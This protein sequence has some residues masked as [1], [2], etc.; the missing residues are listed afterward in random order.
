[1][2]GVGGTPRD[3]SD[4]PVGWDTRHGGESKRELGDEGARGGESE[5]VCGDG[6]GWGGFSAGESGEDGGALGGLEDIVVS[7]WV[8]DVVEEGGRP[9]ASEGAVDFDGRR[10]GGI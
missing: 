6:S 8:F 1:M 10:E 2:G 4:T 5:G 9:R 3:G 7:G